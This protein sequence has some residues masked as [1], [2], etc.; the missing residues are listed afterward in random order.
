MPVEHIMLGWYL[1]ILVF[2]GN[3]LVMNRAIRTHREIKQIETRIINILRVR[4]R[5][6]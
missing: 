6:R 5:R 3:F 1:G 4:K 2:G